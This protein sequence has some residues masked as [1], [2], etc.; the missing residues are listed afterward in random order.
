[1]V[2]HCL[3]ESASHMRCLP[4]KP[5][6]RLHSEMSLGSLQDASGMLQGAEGG[7]ESALEW[8]RARASKQSARDRGGSVM[9]EGEGD[10]SCN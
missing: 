10:P 9:L 5:G 1:M 2:A 8:V 7:V 4:A 6:M 3:R